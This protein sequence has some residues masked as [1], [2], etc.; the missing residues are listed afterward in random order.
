MQD[1]PKHYHFYVAYFCRSGHH[2]P[3]DVELGCYETLQNLKLEYLDLYL[4][5]YLN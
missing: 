2:N 1:G 3:E 5:C 4:V